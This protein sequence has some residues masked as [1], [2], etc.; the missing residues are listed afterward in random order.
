MCGGE[1]TVCGIIPHLW[2]PGTRLDSLDA[3]PAVP[4][5]SKVPWPATPSQHPD[6]VDHVLGM[7]P[8]G[9]DTLVA[10]LC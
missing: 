7:M 3:V 8:S 9:L 6:V 5:S 4:S 2:I 1:R 10:G